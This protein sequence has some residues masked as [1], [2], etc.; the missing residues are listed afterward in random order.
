M[1]GQCYGCG[2]EFG[3]FK[4]EHGCKNCGFA[5]CSNCLNKKIAVPKLD[6]SKHHVCNKCYNVLTGKAPAVETER[7]SPP[8]AYL[9]RVAALEQKESQGGASSSGHK[10]GASKVNPKYIHLEKPDREIAMRL[11]KLKEKPQEQKVTDTDLNV[12]LAQLKGE[13]PAKRTAPTK[14]FYQPPDRRTQVEQIDDLLDEIANEVEIDSHRPDPAAYVED[15]LA[16]L[17]DQKSDADKDEK[18][19]LDK[20]SPTSVKNYVKNIDVGANGSGANTAGPGHTTSAATTRG[21][22]GGPGG[23]EDEGGDVDVAE[24]QALMDRAASQMEAE[25]RRA[26]EG[27]KQDK[28]LM[29]RLAQVQQRHR[30]KE[31][32]ADDQSEGSGVDNTLQDEDSEDEDVAA[33]R[34]LT[35]YL[36]EAKL[37]EKAEQ[38]LASISTPPDPSTSKTKKGKAKATAEAGRPKEGE[39]PDSDYEDPDELPYCIICTEDAV[40]RCIDCD[41]DLYCNRCFREGHKELGLSDHRSVSYKA[42]KGYR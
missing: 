41:M 3:F 12:R 19:N 15:R 10:G 6:G 38:D 42:P 27:M 1:P 18:N 39:G 26:L 37:D 17:R 28:A 4:K 21:G 35:Q 33:Q 31:G 9:K 30:Q 29:E 11:E 34:I 36:A 23:G 40:V 7:Y 32:Q 16:R 5:F 8:K 22:G 24:V 14:P 13:D 2:E 20:T 25:A